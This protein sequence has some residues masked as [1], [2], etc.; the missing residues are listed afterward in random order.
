VNKS[1]SSSAGACALKGFVFLLVIVF[2]AAAARA[3]EAAGEAAVPMT[4]R[5]MLLVIQ[6]GVILFAAKIGNMLFEKIK[7]PG[8]LGE[9]V[10]GII[11]SPYLFGKIAFHG[12]ERGLFPLYGNSPLWPELSALVSVAAVVLL[13][14]VGLETDIGMLLRYSFAGSVVGIG[15]VL[16]SFFMGAGTMVLFSEY[17]FGH[18]LGFL[19][20]QAL[21]LGVISTAT[22]VGITAR[23]LADKKKLASPEGVTILTAA[24]IDDVIGIVLL[25]IVMGMV[26]ATGASGVDWGH[27]MRIGAQAMG[28]WLGVT[29]VGLL[30]SR[31]ISFLLKLFGE[32]SSIAVMALGLALIL[33]GLFEEAGLAMIIGAYVMGL[34]LSQSDISHLIREKL[35]PLYVFLVPIFFCSMGM[36]INLFAMTSVS[37][38]AFG[39]VYAL[40][41]MSSKILGCGL[42]ALLVNFNWRGALRIGF[43]MAPRCEVALI[44]ASVA[45]SGGELTQE[46]FAA[47]IF[48]VII[49]TVLAPTALS[50]LFHDGKPGARKK[51]EASG[52]GKI[53]ISFDFPSPVVADFILLQ[54][55]NIFEAEG[56]FVHAFS[57]VS[58][59]YQMRRDS[60]IIDFQYKDGALVFEC[61]QKE[62]PFLNTAMMEAVAELERA[63]QE[64]KKPMDV[65]A[66]G[67]RVQEAGKGFP[68]SLSLKNYITPSL[69]KPRLRGSSKEEVIDELLDVLKKNK[70]LDKVEDAREAV[71]AREASMSTGLQYGIAVPHGKTGCVENLV[72]AV[73]LKPQGM[74]FD[75]LDG[76]PTKIVILTLSPPDKPAPHVQFMSMVAQVLNKNGLEKVLANT[77]QTGI[78]NA[79]TE[80]G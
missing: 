9:L 54:L 15:G 63:V 28:V 78:Y 58:K 18:K 38:L 74:D 69:I 64:L 75:S 21:F 3:S 49:N 44:I 17:I 19:S 62:T 70:L 79:L 71:L 72:C 22:S 8:A 4:H 24:V 40:V 66:I 34:S 27:V 14:T 68:P 56:F 35:Y 39:V 13:F 80:K 11:L 7:L 47:V 52:D 26:G 50:A 51:L 37:I 5:M 41:A 32:G 67:T 45:L 77:S 2:S 61:D 65:K 42:P 20:P 23:I 55:K 1:S 33:A 76:E 60:T 10:A 46:V 59:I 73:G 53:L 57:R 29:A 25:A 30:A 36:R 12:F 31:K 43:G 16:A 48:M 6:L